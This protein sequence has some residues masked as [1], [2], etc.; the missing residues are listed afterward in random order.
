MKKSTTTPTVED[1]LQIAPPNMERAIFTI[2]G[3]T[4]YVQA[5]FSGRVMAKMVADQMAGS[6]AK[7]KRKRDPK[8]FDALVED[9]KHYAPEGW[10]GMPASAFRSAMISACRTVGFKMTLAKL[11]VFVE[12]DSFDRVDG[13]PLVK[14]THGSPRRVDHAVR[15]ATGVV[16]I[17]PRPMWEPGWKADVT[18][19]WDADQFTA[20]DVLNLLARVGQQVGIG[21]GRPDSK[22]STGMGWGLFDVETVRAIKSK[23]RKRAA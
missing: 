17:R 16:D 8:D 2:V 13:M 10:V 18:I 3:K 21:E 20:Q 11:S 12:A 15:N 6:T 23:P 4:P 5:R 19:R 14:I 9:A 22:S 1:R 7:A